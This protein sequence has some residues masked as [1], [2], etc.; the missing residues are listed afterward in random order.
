MT[1]FVIFLLVYFYIFPFFS[2]ISFV[3]LQLSSLLFLYLTILL[4]F[5]K[6]LPTNGITRFLC[7]FLFRTHLLFS[8]NRNNLKKKR[9]HLVFSFKFSFHLTNISQIYTLACAVMEI[10]IVTFS[11]R[12]NIYHYT[13]SINTVLFIRL[14]NPECRL[15]IWMTLYIVKK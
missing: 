15:I 7:S 11:P 3:K 8:K 2:L 14:S 12:L 6:P 10:S 5:P 1:F 4:F 13:Y 9:P